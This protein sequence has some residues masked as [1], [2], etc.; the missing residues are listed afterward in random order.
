[1]S[2]FDKDF[3]HYY[4]KA[5]DNDHSQSEAFEYAANRE[6]KRAYYKAGLED[7]EPTQAQIVDD[8][9]FEYQAAHKKV[10]Y[11][12]AVSKALRFLDSWVDN[13]VKRIEK[14]KKNVRKHEE[15]TTY[16]PQARSEAQSDQALKEAATT[17]LDW[18]YSS[19]EIHQ[20]GFP[21]V[22]LLAEMLTKY[23][24]YT[25]QGRS[26]PEAWSKTQSW[27]K[28]EVTQRSKHDAFDTMNDL[29]DALPRGSRFEED[30]R[31]Q[32]VQ[33]Q[34][35]PHIRVPPMPEGKGKHAFPKPA[36]AAQ[37]SF[38]FPKQHA[39]FE[40]RGPSGQKPSTGFRN[41]EERVPSGS[42][43]GTPPSSSHDSFLYEQPE[44]FKYPHFKSSQYRRSPPGYS[45]NR[46]KPAQE[47][48]LSAN[49]VPRPST[50]PLDPYASLGFTSHNVTDA[51]IKKV[52]RK[53]ALQYHPDKLGHLSE[54]EKKAAS[55]KFT[56]IANAYEILGD[57]D[58]RKKY[59]E[60]GV[61]P[62][63]GQ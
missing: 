61:L 46:P 29:R 63:V 6:F 53:L 49:H 45:T 18:L 55:A 54:E 21:R 40:S 16:R 15:K 39:T 31:E 4:R 60:F 17:H 38:P 8:I 30:L 9:L 37:N 28:S 10:G 47:R 14:E 27:A 56:E 35:Q 50:P 5:R 26:H 43:W 11:D 57:A 52:Y 41:V 33:A 51:K 2:S 24:T 7:D 58:N 23:K 36:H 32:K 13:E 44:D 62:E 25:D 12:K 22:T 42:A 3:A 20:D 1:M 48:R 59:Y 34:N 19:Q